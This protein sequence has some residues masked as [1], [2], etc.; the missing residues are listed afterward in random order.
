V[1]SF[2]VQII[3]CA[4]VLALFAKKSVF[5]ICGIIMVALEPRKRIWTGD[6]KFWLPSSAEEVK[7]QLW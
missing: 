2:I 6:S 4:K 3:D 5:C 1:L 7:F